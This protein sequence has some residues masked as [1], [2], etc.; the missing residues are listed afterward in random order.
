MKNVK[1][2]EAVMTTMILRISAVNISEVVAVA[3][4][5]TSTLTYCKYLSSIVRQSY[6]QCDIIL[7]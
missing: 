4:M 7:V 6:R 5:K 3:K 2:K 1:V